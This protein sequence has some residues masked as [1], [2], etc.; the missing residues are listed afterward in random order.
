MTDETDD[1]RSHEIIDILAI[2]DPHLRSLELD[3]VDPGEFQ[4][5]KF[6]QDSVKAIDPG[7]YLDHTPRYHN[8]YDNEIFD[9]FY[10]QPDKQTPEFVLFLVR[11]YQHFEYAIEHGLEAIRIPVHVWNNVLMRCQA[12]S[13]DNELVDQELV[14]F[15][16]KFVELRVKVSYPAWRQKLLDLLTPFPEAFTL[17]YRHTKWISSE[18]YQL[19]HSVTDRVVLNQHLDH[20]LRIGMAKST[21]FERLFYHMIELDSILLYWWIENDIGLPDPTRWDED[22]LRAFYGL[23]YGMC[24]ESIHKFSM[25]ALSTGRFT[26]LHQDDIFRSPP[27]I[28]EALRVEMFTEDKLRKKLTKLTPGTCSHQNV[29]RVLERRF[30]KSKKANG[31]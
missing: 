16:E 17:F 10:S 9:R 12:Q 7:A 27:L 31:Q 5:F 3:K 20:L 6:F 11:N 2:P 26:L 14:Q 21:L 24:L 22:D 19:S 1:V 29:K 23:I 30:L 28:E 8:Y 13:N 18:R 25:Y 4:S 15:Y